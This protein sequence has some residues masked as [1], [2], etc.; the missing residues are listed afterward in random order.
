MFPNREDTN[1]ELSCGVS[2]L[3]D[4]GWRIEDR[5]EGDTVVHS[6]GTHV[7]E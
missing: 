4:G 7:G 3:E 5:N 6:Q 1:A 2:E